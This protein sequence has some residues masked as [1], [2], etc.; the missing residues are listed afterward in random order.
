VF[1]VVT[2]A[3]MPLDDRTAMQRMAVETLIDAFGVPGTGG[4]SEAAP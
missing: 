2:P 3:G 4:A 1:T